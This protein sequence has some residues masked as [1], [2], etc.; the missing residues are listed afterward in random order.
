MLIGWINRA[1]AALL[2][3]SS[4]L[5]SLPGSNVQTPHVARAWH[6]AAGVRA[7]ALTLDMGASVS[8]QLLG[9]M[10]TNLSAAATVRVRASDADPAAL[11]SLLL[12][13]GTLAATAKAGYGQTYHDLAATTA[14]YWRVDL[15]DATAPE[16]LQVGRLFLGP[17]WQPSVNQEYGWSVSN[18]DPSEVD[19]SYGGQA[20]S[21]TRPHRRQLMFTLNW[22]SESEMYGNAFAAARAVGMVGDVLAVHNS[23]GGARIAEQSVFGRLMAVTDITHEKAR[24]FRTKFTVKEAL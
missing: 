19:E 15:A 21:S 17:R 1:D 6:T 13:S 22:M 9:L 4:E 24:I 7:A 20:Y 3:A 14:R 12:D 10:G 2:S 18:I 23:I 16:N 8:C 11:A 5:A